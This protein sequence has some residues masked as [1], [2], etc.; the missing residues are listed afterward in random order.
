MMLALTLFLVS[1]VVG[2]IDPIVA[3]VGI[4]SAVVFLRVGPVAGWITMGAGVVALV[5]LQMVIS[6]AFQDRALPDGAVH[7]LSA[8]AWFGLVIVVTR[9]IRPKRPPVGP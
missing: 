8:V 7:A 2:M 9:I 6:R 1:I 5:V 4:I 3:G